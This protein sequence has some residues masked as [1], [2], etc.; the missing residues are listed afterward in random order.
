MLS[1]HFLVLFLEEICVLYR[2]TRREIYVDGSE[3]LVSACARGSEPW[4]ARDAGLR[5]LHCRGM[6]I[7]ST[8]MMS[9]LC[10][11]W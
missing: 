4:P 10:S 7:F 5:A 6:V 3:I 2:A 11:D 8:D 9:I 1:P